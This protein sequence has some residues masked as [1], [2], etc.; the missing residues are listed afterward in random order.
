[1]PRPLRSLSRPGEARRGTRSQS[2]DT[3]R[4]S[5]TLWLSGECHSGIQNLKTK[6]ETLSNVVRVRGL[7]LYFL[8]HRLLLNRGGM[9]S[10]RIVGSLCAVLQFDCQ[11]VFRSV[12]ALH[13]RVFAFSDAG[14]LRGARVAQHIAHVIPLGPG[15]VCAGEILTRH[16]AEHFVSLV[17]LWP[18]MP[19]GAWGKFP[20]VLDELR[21]E[22]AVN[23]RRRRQISLITRWSA[24][25]MPSEH[26]NP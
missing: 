4:A 25:P 12:D 20:H 18:S 10:A 1:M 9:L 8:R 19:S 17:I 23:N 13:L 16:Y 14:L 24:L 5:A 3:D 21:P 26:P 22:A 15:A 7:W 6:A 2:L 11:S